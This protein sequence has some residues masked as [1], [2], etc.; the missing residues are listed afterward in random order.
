MSKSIG[1]FPY[2]KQNP[3]CFKTQLFAEKKII[4]W[5]LYGWLF[6]LLCEVSGVWSLVSLYSFPLDEA[7][8]RFLYLSVLLGQAKREELRGQENHIFFRDLAKTLNQQDFFWK[9][10]KACLVTVLDKNLG[11]YF[12][13]TNTHTLTHRQVGAAGQQ[14]PR[15]FYRAI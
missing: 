13:H 8:M 1:W 7:L 10:S 11:K 4:Y 14:S 15:H 12:L 6:F 5:D 9:I 3:T 2:W